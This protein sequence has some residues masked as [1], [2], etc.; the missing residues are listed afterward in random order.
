MSAGERGVSAWEPPAPGWTCAECYFE[1][2]AWA[3]AA[4]VEAFAG[5]GR[6]YRAPL[7]K[8]LPG[9]DLD[10]LVRTRPA[11]ETW[12]AL[13]YA[14]HTRDV[15]RLTDAR[16]ETI[17]AADRPALARFDPEMAAIE[18]D[19]ADEGRA[20]VA[21]EIAAVASS[22]A[23]RLGAAAPTDWSRVG[24]CEDAELSV[25]WLAV[26]ALHEGAHHLLDIGRALRKAR[27][28]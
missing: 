23:T 1:Y 28:R 14:C 25:H 13:E 6:K 21:A 8:G 9:E 20:H 15:F 3:P 24:I 5:S 11:P 12:S 26:N 18:H 22:L 17:L 10:A 2:D 7:T 27:G 4:I 16:I 19:Y